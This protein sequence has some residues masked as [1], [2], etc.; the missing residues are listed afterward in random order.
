MFHLKVAFRNI[1]NG[2]VPAVNVRSKIIFVFGVSL[3]IGIVAENW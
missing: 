3:K 1:R 2:L